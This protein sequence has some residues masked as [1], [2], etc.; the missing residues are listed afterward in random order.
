[1]QRRRQQAQT[2]PPEV[3]E[4]SFRDY[5]KRTCPGFAW[6]PHT[7]RLVAIGQEVGERKQRRLMVE[8]PPRHWKS[9]IFSRLLPGWCLRREPNATIGLGANTQAL[10][11]EFSEAAK[12]FYKASGGSLSRSTSGKGRW[13]TGGGRGGLWT[14]G[15]GKGT[16][17]PADWLFIDDP[18]KGREEAESAAYRRQLHNWWDTVLS[19]REEPGNCIVIIHTRWHENDLI[20][21]LL[22]KAEELESEGLGH[23]AIPWHVVSMPMLAEPNPKVLPG[24]VT[25]EPDPR[26]P[27]EA[28]DPSY[29]NEE[30]AER[31]R[32]NMSPRDWDAIYQQR[33]TSAGGTIFQ[34]STFRFYLRPGDAQGLEGDVK[35]PQ[36]FVRVLCSLDC[37]FKDSDGTDMVGIGIWGQNHQGMWLLDIVDQRMGFTA[38]LDTVKAL[39]VVWQFGELLVEDKANGPAI[40]DT[41]KQARQGFTVREVHPLGG[42]IAR[43]NAAAPQFEQGRVFF[44][45]HASW[46]EKYCRQLL[47]FPSGNFD[48]QVD[49]TTQVLN[50]IAGT[51]PMT[52]T[53]VEFGYGGQQ[54]PGPNTDPQLGWSEAALHA[55]RSA[56]LPGDSL[57]DPYADL[58]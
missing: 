32:V 43:A 54:I 5:I 15:V 20:G 22:N 53:T 36:R 46:R 39:Y 33:P 47:Q 52:V 23:L 3:Y 25:S 57:V 10:A 44:P 34:A 28:L 19:T 21:Y 56:S 13:I 38:T 7:E 24:P 42:K 11:E 29:Y 1:M 26:K 31:Q 30:W 51:G 12:G 45:R 9:T 40:I 27:G 6:K 49:Q 8:L 55:M 2:G 58:L 14:A 18:I 48:D 4:E 35:L 16:G 37:T 17:L 50:H 41:L